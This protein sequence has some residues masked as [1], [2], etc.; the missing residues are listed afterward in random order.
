MTILAL[1]ATFS[2]KAT[3]YNFY[4]L[5]NGFLTS[6]KNYPSSIPITS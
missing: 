2:E 5:I 6:A 3:T 1:L 4:D